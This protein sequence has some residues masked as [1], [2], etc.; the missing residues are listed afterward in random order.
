MPYDPDKDDP[1][2]LESDD[3]GVFA[4]FDHILTSGG[5]GLHGIGRGS[6]RGL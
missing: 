4:C 6:G 2:Y 1:E 5:A 3:S